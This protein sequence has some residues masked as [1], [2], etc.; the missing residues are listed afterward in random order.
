[1]KYIEQAKSITLFLLIALSLTLT[2]L[3]WNYQPKYQTIE[4][5]QV[6]NTMLSEQRPLSK[7][8]KPYRMLFKLDEEETFTGTVSSKVIDRLMN[9]MAEMEANDLTLINH[10]LSDDK[11]DEMMRLPERMMLFFQDEVPLPTFNVLLP[12]HEKEIAEATFNRMIIDWSK[13]EATNQLQFLFVNTKQHTLH[14]SFVKMNDKSMFK[15]EFVQQAAQFDRYLEVERA[16]APSLYVLMN[17]TEV[18]PY[19]Y[20]AET[21]SPDLLK[22]VLFNDPNIVH[23]S[24]ENAQSEKY[25]DSMSL[26]TIDAQNQ[27]IHYVYP[28]AESIT[29]IAPSTLI[30]DSV[31]FLNEHGGMT[32]DYRF[33]AMNYQKHV[34]DYQ[35]FFKDLPVYSDTT[36]TRISTTWGD[37]RIFRYRRPNYIFDMVLPDDKATKELAS[38]PRTI[39]HLQ[40]SLKKD[41]NEIEDLVIGYYLVYDTGAQLFTLEPSWFMLTKN[42]WGRLSV[43][44][45]GGVE[46]GLE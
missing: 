11:L 22:R 18:A 6:E 20:F 17:P 37:N 32:A 42:G 26:M 36:L 44:R 21:I 24:I 2:F 1:M 25:T 14:R 33:A 16:A 43:E 10:N 31:E 27:S 38:G 8:I 34:I 19:T 46:Y 5:I 41:I 12:F 29:P 7:V 30:K 23:R 35:M 45:V 13:L 15:R 40:Y 39:E 4:H 28:T 3:T 9:S